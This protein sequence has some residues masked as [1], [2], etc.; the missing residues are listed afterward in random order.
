MM[1]SNGQHHMVN[2]LL[3]QGQNNTNREDSNHIDIP[4]KLKQRILRQHIADGIDYRGFS[5]K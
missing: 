5:K 1:S 3:K 2:S 4:E